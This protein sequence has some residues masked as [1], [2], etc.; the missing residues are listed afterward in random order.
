MIPQ[1]LEEIFKDESNSVR[2]IG[3]NLDIYSGTILYHINKL[4]ELNL[5]KSTK[6]KAGKK[7]FL[8][9]FELLKIYNEFFKEPDFSKLLRGL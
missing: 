4:K 3:E 1:L 5:V 6:N 8:V 7:I 9:N 2:K